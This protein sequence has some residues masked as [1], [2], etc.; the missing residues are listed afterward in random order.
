MTF[1][2]WMRHRGLARRGGLLL[3][4]KI[5][6]LLRTPQLVCILR[7]IAHGQ[8]QFFVL[9]HSCFCLPCSD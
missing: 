7:A 6:L 2:D 4:W 8:A 1:E 3:L 9:G 5:L